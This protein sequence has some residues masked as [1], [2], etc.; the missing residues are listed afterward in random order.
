MVR[1]GTWHL[2]VK[3]SHGAIWRRLE[4]MNTHRYA[5][6]SKAR[7]AALAFGASLA[8]CFAASAAM[9]AATFDVV[10]Q[11]ILALAKAQSEGRVTSLQLVDA[12]LARIAK[13]DKTGPSLHSVLAINSLARAQARA[14]DAERAAGHVRGPLH[15][16][17][18]LVK[19]NI[20]TADPMPTT[21]GSLALAANIGH[22]DAPLVA[23]LRAAGAVILGKTN[24][25]EWAN[26]RSSVSVSGWSAVGGQTRNPYTL[27]RNACGSS[28]G[29]AAAVAASLAAA[30]IGTETDGSITCP[31]SMT[32]LVGIK[33][34]VGLVSRTFV[35]PISHSQDTP[36]P[37]TH[38]VADAAL[39]LGIMAGSDPLD[40]AT[41]DADKHIADLTN[42]APRDLHGVRIGV[43]RVS[44][45]LPAV[46]ALLEATIARLGAAGAT[47]VEV[48]SPKESDK[49]N[50]LE[51]AVMLTEL[52]ADLG[53]YLATTPKEVE[54]RTLADV[55]A[56]NQSHANEEMPI[57]GQDLFEKAQG[58]LG[59]Q[60]TP[61]LEA[62]ETSRRIA[63]RDGLEKM[64]SAQQLA[65]IIAPTMGPAFLIDQ[66]NGD[67]INASGPGNLP[68]IAGFPHL[69]VP[70]GMVKGLPV[71]LSVIGA[72]WSDKEV[73]ALG[74]ALETI[75]GHVPR[76]SYQPQS[77]IYIQ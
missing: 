20:E 8:L 19:D 38:T 35:V 34:T 46:K 23:R 13:L 76:P 7:A 5:N 57:F 32:G 41:R 33:P 3:N 75:V 10:G 45:A 49:L 6:R 11:P 24:L 58:T 59:L 48:E 74:G 61:Y 56:F 50:D 52:K 54:V 44:T 28:S 62:L 66:I 55:I 15:G 17:P 4:I 1:V 18:L 71:G 39:L 65:A 72:A 37:L 21:A 2:A 25:S 53:N 12:Y 36:G 27:D 9:A 30:A 63:G 67:A 42:S 73:L 26:I 68:A 70:M 31:A 69:T 51:L 60:D 29:S 16:I 77:R 14:L 64:F 40:P 22:R 47:V 43:M